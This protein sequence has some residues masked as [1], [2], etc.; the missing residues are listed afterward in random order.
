MRRG[1]CAAL[2][3]GMLALAGCA[4]GDLDGRFGFG[5]DTSPL[6]RILATSQHTPAYQGLLFVAI[7]D[8]EAAAQSAGRA[9]AAADNL[10]E[11]RSSLGEVVYAVAPEAA[12]DW[13]AKQAGLIPGWA[14]TGY[15]V[16]RAVREMAAE[17]RALHGGFGDAP[18][19]ALVCAQNTLQWSEQLLD[20]ASRAP[21]VDGTD[22]LRGLLLQIEDLARALN[23]GR[24]LDDDDV[25]E[26]E[27]G[28]CGLQA[29]ERLLKGVYARRT[30]V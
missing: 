9:V 15:G 30:A 21:E 4:P 1:T 22:Q 6:Q 27:Q 8:A 7:K 26:V 23:E 11:V 5:E 17:L 29:M 10:A 19:Q 18:A 28:E 20:L 16:R 25:I 2:A 13:R 24:D 14:A 12:P 3:A